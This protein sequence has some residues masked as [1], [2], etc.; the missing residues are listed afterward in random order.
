MIPVALYSVDESLSYSKLIQLTSFLVDG[1]NGGQR[2]FE[3][4]LASEASPGL[5]EF[6]ERIQ[7]QFFLKV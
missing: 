1:M 6:H 7:V 4:F 5:R 3:I 2:E